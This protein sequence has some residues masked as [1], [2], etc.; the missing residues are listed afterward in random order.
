MPFIS[1]QPQYYKHQYQ[2]ITDDTEALL[3]H[4]LTTVQKV[5]DLC[6]RIWC[7]GLSKK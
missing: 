1:P 4:E 5:Q 2:H 3:R 6:Q 7:V